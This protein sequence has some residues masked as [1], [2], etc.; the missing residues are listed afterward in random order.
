MEG[1]NNI[2][3]KA[4]TKARRFSDKIALQLQRQND[5]EQVYQS[6]IDSQPAMV[7]DLHWCTRQINIHIYIHP[8]YTNMYVT[9]V[10]RAGSVPPAPRA[11]DHIPLSPACDSGNAARGLAFCCAL[12]K[13]A[14]PCFPQDTAPYGL[15]DPPSAPVTFHRPAP[16]TYGARTRHAS[17]PSDHAPDDMLALHFASLLSSRA[18]SQPNIYSQSAHSHYTNQYHGSSRFA[19]SD[20]GGGNS[21]STSPRTPSTPFSIGVILGCG[22]VCAKPSDFESQTLDLQRKNAH[23]HYRA[24]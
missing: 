19:D 15:H 24:T 18:P 4:Q 8:K 16:D 17:L 21:Y 2:E 13:H 7:C 10:I 11:S 9:H 20:S 3:V 1:K 5:L 12:A 14:R 6:E 22:G 23:F